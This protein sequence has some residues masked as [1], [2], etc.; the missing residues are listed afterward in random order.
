M[1]A[2]QSGGLPSSTSPLRVLAGPHTGSLPIDPP[3]FS[4]NGADNGEEPSSDAN[5][6]VLSKGQ[7]KN[8]RRAQ[9]KQ[10]R[11]QRLQLH[12]E[13]RPSSDDLQ[14]FVRDT[15]THCPC[16]TQLDAADVA[17]SD[18]CS[19]CWVKGP[20]RAVIEC[21]ALIDVDGQ[22]YPCGFS[23]CGCPCKSTF[24]NSGISMAQMYSS[25]TSST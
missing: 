13:H 1:C 7:K 12:S 11:Q 2:S 22:P 8:R 24:G 6:A 14:R 5:N 10:L 18:F 21:P 3:A 16:G 9:T 20:Y 4:D 23:W 17:T 19:S 15:F 25:L